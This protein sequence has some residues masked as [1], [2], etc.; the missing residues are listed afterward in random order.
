MFNVGDVV[1]TKST[2]KTLGLIIDSIYVKMNDR[3]IFKIFFE[4]SDS[5]EWCYKIEFDIVKNTDKI[6]YMKSIYKDWAVLNNVSSDQAQ[7]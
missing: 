5:P 6:S 2:P 3:Y 4:D 7:D 1:L